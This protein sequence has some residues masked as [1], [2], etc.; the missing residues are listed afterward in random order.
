M[1][2]QIIGGYKILEKIGEGGMGTVYKGIDILLER[3]VAIKL[4]R[5]ELAHD[6][7]LIKRFR[8]EAVALARLN[9]PNIV[10]LYSFL[11][12]NDQFFMALE[13]VQGET[14]DKIIKRH[15]AMPWQQAIS[16]ICQALNGL[17][18]AH[19][20]KVVHRDIKPANMAVTPAGTL[21]LMDFGIARILQT[22]RLTRTGHLFGT[23]EYMS[24]EQVQGKETDS[25]S[26]IYSLGIVL[27]EMLTGHIPFTGHSDFELL[28]AQVEKL[29]Q[30]PRSLTPQLPAELDKVVLRALAK[31]PEN[32]FQ[33]AAEFRTALE[34]T[35]AAAPT[36]SGSHQAPVI[37]P[38]TRF[39][40]SLTY[41]RTSLPASGKS[42]R[43]V[44]ALRR[45]NS[46][47]YIRRYPGVIVS[48]LMLIGAA[49]FIA[50]AHRSGTPARLSE[51]HT[52]E[53]ASAVS[54]QAPAGTVQKP[55]STVPGQEQPAA[56][57]LQQ[58]PIVTQPQESPLSPPAKAVTE[59][60]PMPV[61][62][63]PRTVQQQ[64]TTE[65]PPEEK[66]PVSAAPVPMSIPSDRLAPSVAAPPVSPSVPAPEKP[67]PEKNRKT[68]QPR[69]P[70][71]STSASSSKKESTTVS[72]NK[73]SRKSSPRPS[74]SGGGS[75]GWKIIY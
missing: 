31:A 61:Q 40:N 75:G 53:S 13:F 50:I 16:L 3:Q 22:A 18:H 37:L 35:M 2:G 9:H 49:T 15:G 1:I 55:I 42:P 41:P 45:G 32:R 52:R 12:H 47:T 38:E 63:P 34:N 11:P 17:E 29:P 57:Q 46:L 51:S 74:S 21:K 6:Q 39:D 36:F 56:A 20:F 30:P 43:V 23:L 64:Q 28:K 8:A 72:S 54:N 67:K 27:Y 59:T 69:Q 58:Q 19:S 65:N 26:D 4:L 5:P 68:M 70:A 7:G 24:P 66:I 73:S 62:E 60:Q 14:L 10:M 25:R 44:S 33:N 48:V 71:K